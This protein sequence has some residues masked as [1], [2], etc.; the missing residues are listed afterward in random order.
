M[1]YD[2]IALACEQLNYRDKLRLAQLLIQ[3][4]RKEEET[5]NPKNRTQ[6]TTAQDISKANVKSQ[7]EPVNTIEY[8]VDRLLKLRPS[9]KKSLV[10]SIKAMYQFQ[11]GI[12]DTDVEKII[13]DLQKK[14]HIRIDDNKVF[15]L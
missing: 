12:S 6:K 9:K 10:N 5:A 13:T 8:I 15:Y 1:T 2:V 14:K 7:S 11:G 3:L 4:A